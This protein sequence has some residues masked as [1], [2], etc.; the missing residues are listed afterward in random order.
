MAYSIDELVDQFNDPT[1][2]QVQLCRELDEWYRYHNRER[3]K[4]RRLAFKLCR[5]QKIRWI[6]RL[7]RVIVR[8]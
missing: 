8:G 3:R 4:A 2:D 7:I 6:K 5:Q 1:V